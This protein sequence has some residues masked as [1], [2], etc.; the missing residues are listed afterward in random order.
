MEGHIKGEQILLYTFGEPRVGCAQ[1]AFKFDELI[2]YRL[3][4]GFRLK[5][6]FFLLTAI[7]W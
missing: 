5:C 2:P 6:R 1:F 4:L 7:E 3:G